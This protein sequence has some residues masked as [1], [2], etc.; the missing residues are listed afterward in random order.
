MDK[1]AAGL[2]VGRGGDGV[3]PA[4]AARRSSIIERGGVV[5][6]LAFIAEVWLGR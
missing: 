2:V 4:S 5:R 3:P 1:R 6:A